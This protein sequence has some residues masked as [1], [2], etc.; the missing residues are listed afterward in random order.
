M[1]GLK[2]GFVTLRVLVKILLSSVTYLWL[3]DL[4]FLGLHKS[5]RFDNSYQVVNNSLNYGRYFEY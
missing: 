2:A 5:T 4:F 1:V 3:W